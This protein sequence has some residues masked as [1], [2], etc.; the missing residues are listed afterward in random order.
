MT[1]KE[2]DI[3][4]FNYI[5][6]VAA[7]K[8]DTVIAPNTF[9]DIGPV[10]PSPDD[11][12][13]EKES[14]IA[15]EKWIT[16]L[17]LVPALVW[18]L[19]SLWKYLDPNC[20]RRLTG[21]LNALNE[22]MKRLNEAASQNEFAA[23]AEAL[24][25]IFQALPKS[26]RDRVFQNDEF[27][28]ELRRIA[29]GLAVPLDQLIGKYLQ[30]PNQ[31]SAL[32]WLVNYGTA[33]AT[34]AAV[35]LWALNQPGSTTGIAAQIAAWADTNRA[36]LWTIAGVAVVLGLAQAVTGFGIPTGLATGAAGIILLALLVWLN[37]DPPQ[38]NGGGMEV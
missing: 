35:Y 10:T 26:C 6:K 37:A 16:G 2:S 22:A 21:S 36:L 17:S 7:R 31:D 20:K 32:R 8:G 1:M 24:R 29:N 28:E 38:N 19:R 34:A 27:R 18:A 9:E 13:P 4:L 11:V 14:D 23:A 5:A 12:V 25:N 15:W 33:A 3:R 30:Q